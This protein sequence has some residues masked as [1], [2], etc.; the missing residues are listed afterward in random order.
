MSDEHEGRIVVRPEA[1][2]RDRGQG[3]Q[4]SRALAGDP[5]AEPRQVEQGGLRPR[6]ARVQQVEQVADR[7]Q[8]RDDHDRG[9]RGNRR[10]GD[11]GAHRSAAGR[12]PLLPVQRLHLI[13]V[14]P[15]HPPA[16]R[17]LA[18]LP[19]SRSAP[20]DP[21]PPCPLTMPP[22]PA[23]GLPGDPMRGSLLTVLAAACLAAGG[24]GAAGPASAITNGSPDGNG[25][26][27]VG[28]LVADS[29][30]SDG[31]STYCSGTLI[32]PTVFLTA[33]HC[34]PGTS[35]TRVTFSSAYQDGD[36]TYAGTF[37]ADLS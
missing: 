7:A 20:T 13:V 4:I 15:P 19:L 23:T 26:P 9:E 21:T 12:R 14:A 2:G 24:V 10:P 31:T 1:T 18:A 37:H 27:N 34:D 36:R 17:G 25:H 16:V 35:R 30:Y 6:A 22:C 5:V 32:S 29:V 33:A 8:A 11:E 28:A 3:V